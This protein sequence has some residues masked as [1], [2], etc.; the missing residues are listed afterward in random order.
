[1]RANLDAIV[2]TLGERGSSQPKGRVHAIGATAK[3]RALRL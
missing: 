2:P 3:K 1:M